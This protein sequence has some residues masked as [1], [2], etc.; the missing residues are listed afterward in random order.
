MRS[1]SSKSAFAQGFLAALPFVVVVIP[2][3]MLFGVVATEGGLPIE[4]V[5]AFSFVVVAGASQFAAL[6]FMLEDAPLLVILGSALA[7]NLRMAMYSA[8]IT[9]HLG[10]EPLWKRLIIAYFL[11]DQSYALSIAEYETRPSLTLAEK[12][13][14]FFGAMS[15][16]CPLWYVFSFAGALLGTAIPAENGLDF[17]VPIAFLAMVAPVLRTKAHIAAAVTSATL[18]IVLVWMPFNL[19]L[20]IAALAAMMVGAEWERRST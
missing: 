5:L 9:P 8:S 15:P 7:V 2:F 13:A 3:A 16:I 10:A 4:Q 18:A 14:Y 1:A 12:T 17:I 19:G 20:L 6:Q 11:V